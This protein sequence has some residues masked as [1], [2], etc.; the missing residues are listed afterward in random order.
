MAIYE[1]AVLIKKNCAR[2]R[3]LI[4]NFR[5]FDNDSTLG[6]Q[7][8]RADYGHR[9]TNEERAGRGNDHDGEEAVRGAADEPPGDAD[10]ARDRGV[11]AARAGGEP[12][13]GGTAGR[14]R[15]RD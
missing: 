2:G 4:K 12:T 8:A 7:R 6:G 14:G 13:G 5:V 10:C 3:N 9:Y 1:I 11:P 15:G